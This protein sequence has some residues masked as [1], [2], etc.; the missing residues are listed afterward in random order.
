MFAVDDID[1]RLEK[2]FSSD[3]PK[4]SDEGLFFRGRSLGK[5]ETELSRRWM[6][7]LIVNHVASRRRSTPADGLGAGAP[8]EV[9]QSPGDDV[10][11]EA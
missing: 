7:L 2:G 3:S 10:D 9:G 6:S 1:E 11:S 8:R 5:S 4:N